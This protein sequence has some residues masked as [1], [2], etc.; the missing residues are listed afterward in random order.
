MMLTIVT[1]ALQ[2]LRGAEPQEPV[3]PVRGP[4]ARRTG[5]ARRRGQNGVGTNGATANFMLF[6]SGTY[7][8][9][10]TNLSTSDN[11]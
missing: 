8:V 3:R 9:I 4:L 5:G 2:R 6:D 1:G 7:G 11:I 10:T